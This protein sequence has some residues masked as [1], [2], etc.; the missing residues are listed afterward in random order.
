MLASAA[1]RARLL[2]LITAIAPPLQ[3]PL[4]VL[5]RIFERVDGR[6]AHVREFADCNLEPFVDLDGDGMPV[7]VAP[8]SDSADAE[9][10]RLV[11]VERV[12]ATYATGQ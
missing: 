8:F 4:L 12:L 9:L 2:V 10:K 1:I 7:F 6:L 3:P 5:E 11:P